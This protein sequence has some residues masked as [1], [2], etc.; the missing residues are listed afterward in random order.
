MERCIGVRPFVVL[1]V[2][3]HRMTFLTENC[4]PSFPQNPINFCHPRRERMR[5]GKFAVNGTSPCSCVGVGRTGAGKSVASDVRR[6]R[7]VTRTR[8]APRAGVSA[9][10]P[11]RWREQFM[12]GR[13]R[14]HIGTRP[15]ALE[16]N[17]ALAQHGCAPQLRRVLA[18]NPA[19]NPRFPCRA[20][21]WSERRRARVNPNFVG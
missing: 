2:S 7:P 18:S 16:P 1:Y 11:T 20:G 19:K 12:M 21:P 10:R 14:K 17:C 3:R 8:V 4:A 9:S 6:R 5:A 15:G 13:G